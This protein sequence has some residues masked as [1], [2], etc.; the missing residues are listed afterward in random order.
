MEMLG[1]IDLDKL[2]AIKADLFEKASDPLM[3][4]ALQMIKD[5]ESTIVTMTLN[6]NQYVQWAVEQIQK[7]QKRNTDLSWTV[8]P[9]TSGG[10]FT[11][12]EIDR[13][14]NGSWQ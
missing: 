9:D 4:D 14:R 5:L 8:N 2:D 12:D 10:A 6:H 3:S 7:L 1:K 13:S 11:Q